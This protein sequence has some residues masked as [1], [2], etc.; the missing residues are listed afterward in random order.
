MTTSRPGP[1]RL[2]FF[3]V[4]GAGSIGNDGSLDAAIGYLRERHPEAKLDFLVMGPEHVAAR[5]G[6]PTTHLQWF[7]SHVERFSAVPDVMLKVVGRLLDPIR[8]VQWVRRQDVVIVAGMGVLEGTIPMR[9]WGFPF[10]LLSLAAACRAT[11]TTMLMV[12]VGADYIGNSVIRWMVKKSAQWARYRSYRDVVSR[13]AMQAMGVDVSR[14]TV[15]PDLAFRHAVPAWVPDGTRTVGLGLMDYHGNNDEREMAGELHEAYVTQMKRFAR[16]LVDNGRPIRLFTCDPVDRSV[17]EQIADDLRRCRPGLPASMV[18]DEPASD[19][20]HLMDQM[21]GVDA[22]VATRYHNVVTAIQMAIPTLSV[23]YS[24]K[25]DE[26]MQRVGLG[27]FCQEARSV[28]AA[29]MI[30]QFEELER[31]QAELVAGVREHNRENVAGV[32]RQLV[33]LSEVVFGDFAST[34][35]VARL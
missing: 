13:N 31:E 6:V 18:V 29:R 12:T 10:G 8:T 35:V 11:N 3:G 27:A 32:E 26:V 22:V 24:R 9:P 16:W 28:D 21:T 34:N 14:D 4:L 7:E 30:E 5:Y 33:E 15:H 20:A 2:G 19:L 25:H 23:S 1:T 17:I